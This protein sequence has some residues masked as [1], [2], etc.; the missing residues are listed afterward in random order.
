MKTNL[1]SSFFYIENYDSDM[2]KSKLITGIQKIGGF[3][4][5]FKDNEKILLKPNL[6]ASDNPETGVIT[7]PIF[8]E[9]VIKFFLSQIKE[10]NINL[11]LACGD[12]PAIS[13][14]KKV[15]REAG[16]YQICEKY[17]I[18]FIEFIHKTTLNIDKASNINLNNLS[19]NGFDSKNN[20]NRTQSKNIIKN[21]DIS[22]EILEYDKIISLPK[23]KNHSLT[24]F[25]GGIKNLFG[26]IPGKTKA[27]YH[28]RFPDSVLFS[29]MLVDLADSLKTGICI[30]DG[31][32]AHEGHGPRGGNPIKL[33]YII[34][35]ENPFI[36][37][38]LA[39]TLVGY[40]PAQIP[41][42]KYYSEKHGVSLN[43]K[44][45]EISGDSLVFRKDFKRISTYKKT[46]IPEKY[47]KGFF[48]N[49]LISSRPSFDRKK[50]ILCMQCYNICPTNPKS[51][52]ILN[53]HRIKD[54]YKDAN[55]SQSEQNIERANIDYNH[56]NKLKLK[57]NYDTC[58][59]CFCCQEICPEKAIIIKHSPV[60]KILRKLN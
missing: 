3:S 53:K 7:H 18:P 27:Y 35:G 54:S 50:C 48:Y 55:N 45:H 21:F 41:F 6:L 15:A 23:L 60:S 9:G 1:S 51:I 30:M 36:V 44:D 56:K 39:S 47:R 52:S 25:T 34:I 40:D 28:T 4:K 26:C 8:L 19:I 22:K 38:L 37:D 10:N 49:Y 42:L 2:I 31:I 11:T 58:I 14:A 20:S 16:I 5:F 59:R 32:I 24:L 43:I 33:G 46:V 17:N 57:Y 12:S 13:S 29:K